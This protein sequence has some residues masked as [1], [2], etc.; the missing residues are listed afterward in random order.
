MTGDFV[1]RRSDHSRAELET[2][3]LDAGAAHMA[4]TGFARFSAREVAKRVG[5]SVGTL[6]NLFGS[7]DGFI[8]A[9]N[10]RTLLSWTEALRARLSQSDSDRIALLVD[11][12]FDFAESNMSA[13]MALYD[14]RLPAG[15]ATPEAFNQALSGLTGLIEAEVGRALGRDLDEGT[16]ALTGSLVSI[17]HG[18]CTFGLNGTYQTFGGDPR[19]AALARIREALNAAGQAGSR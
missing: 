18:H 19:Q 4:Q 15:E 8:V 9:L 16:R 12:Y 6:Y 7:Y 1:G 14:H 3:F 13:W 17:V 11:G 10:T 5:Y 2:L